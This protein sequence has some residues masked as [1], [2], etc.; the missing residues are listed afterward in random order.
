MAGTVGVVGVTCTSG[1]TGVAGVVTTVGTPGTA[2]VVTIT[3]T[4]G[5]A[6]TTWNT[7]PV[8]SAGWMNSKCTGA[9]GA[10]EISFLTRS[11]YFSGTRSTLR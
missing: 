2:G 7:G 1:V 9:S 8:P 6:G 3:G 10:L 5:T 4:V 11:R